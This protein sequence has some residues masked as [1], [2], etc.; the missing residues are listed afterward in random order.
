MVIWKYYLSYGE[1][2]YLFNDK[3]AKI[4]NIYRYL[5]IYHRRK[6]KEKLFTLSYIIEK[7]VHIF[8]FF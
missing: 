1:E 4:F 3:Y 6:L 5:E 7:T 8:F 2:Y